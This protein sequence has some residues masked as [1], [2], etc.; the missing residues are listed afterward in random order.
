MTSNSGSIGGPDCTLRDAITAANLD[1]AA[2]GCPAGQGADTII[3]AAGQGYLFDQPDSVTVDNGVAVPNALPSL[4]S[5]IAIRGGEGSSIVRRPGTSVPAFRLLHLDSAAVVRI[6]GVQ[7][8]NG[9]TPGGAGGGGIFNAGQLVLVNSYVYE[10]HTGGGSN[11]GDGGAI[12]N[13]GTLTLVG[14]GAFANSTGS[15][16]DFTGAAGRGGAIFNSGMLLL[17][18]T[19]IGNNQTGASTAVL[20]AGEGGDGGGIFNSGTLIATDAAIAWNTTNSGLDS[21]GRGGG[22]FNEGTATLTRTVVDNNQTGGAAGCGI[23]GY[24]GGVFNSGVLSM[25]DGQVAS[26]INAATSLDGAATYPANGA[27]GGG[28][29]NTG[30]ASV[31]GTTIALNR[32]GAGDLAGDGGGVFNSGMMQLRTSTVYSNAAGQGTEH[33]GQGGGIANQGTLLIT[34]CTI[35]NNWTLDNYAGGAGGG[36]ENSGTLSIASSTISDNFTSDLERRFQPGGGCGVGGGVANVAGSVDIRNTILANNVAADGG[37]DCSGV[38]AS[39]RYSLLGDP[40]ACLVTGDRTGTVTMVAP[41]IGPLGNHGGPTETEALGAGSPAI[42]AGD[43]TGCTDAS[44]TMLTTD[45]RG[46]PRVSPA[47]G[48]CDIGAFEFGAVVPTCPG[49]CD[50]SG[51]VTIS[52]LIIGVNIALG[53]V[54]A[55]ACP[56]FENALGA[57]DIAQLVQGVTNALNGCASASG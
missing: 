2:G 23:G 30:T 52:D 16:P 44:G 48:R 45:Q 26:N 22:L 32:A 19:S 41:L 4:T 56:A 1:T 15:A 24:G 20:D 51:R 37:A 10:S 55:S 9:L 18:G 11:G 57:V 50:G 5:A 46:A 21:G 34:D 49:D 35:S 29:C 3:L 17:T 36:I 39:L 28:V 43:P 31:S 53:T 47:D 54:P 13:S 6:E 42:D 12:F 38:V 40:T 33:G 27:S 7:L 14:G 8:L 25:V